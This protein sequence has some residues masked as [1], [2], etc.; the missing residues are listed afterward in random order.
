MDQLTLF[1]DL[2]KEPP[3][4]AA[5]ERAIEGEVVEEEA[6]E[7]TLS[8]S[9]KPEDPP[10]DPEEAARAEL[11]EAVQEKLSDLTGGDEKELNKLLKGRD[12][13]QMPN[14]ALSKLLIEIAG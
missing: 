13:V 14:E 7:E 6:P 8:D 5:R 4:E 2:P 3:H 1:H 10:V 9:D 12:P 11:I